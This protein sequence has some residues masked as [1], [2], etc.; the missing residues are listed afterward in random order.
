MADR[1][2]IYDLL[3]RAMRAIGAVGKSGH[4]RAQ[5][6]S[7]RAVDDVIAAVGPVLAGLGIT[8]GAEV[9]SMQREPA[10]ETRNGAPQYTTLLHIRYTFS[11]PDGSSVTT[12]AIGEGKDSAD[13]GANKAMS[14]ALKYALCHAL[15]IPTE[16]RSDPEWDRV[17]RAT[18]DGAAARHVRAAKVALLRATVDYRRAAGVQAGDGAPDAKEWLLR[19]IRDRLG[20]ETLETVEEVADVRAAGEAGEYEPATG[21]RV[22]ALR[23]QTME[24]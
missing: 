1:E 20:G 10:G 24:D 16:D 15:L 19:V 18:P 12:D 13:K 7:F 21:E 6:Y 2:T 3:P 14:A 17:D 8:F 9:L 4:N 22:P 5:N 23:S 11:A